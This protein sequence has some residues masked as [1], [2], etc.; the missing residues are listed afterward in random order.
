[1]KSQT[2]IGRE[3]DLFANAKNWKEYWSSMISA[4][5][6]GDVLEVG[7]GMGANTSFLKSSCVTSW[8]CLDPDVALTLQMRENF[9]RHPDLRDCRIEV[10]STE[11]IENGERFDAI[12][13][14]DVLEHISDDKGEVQR[15][16]RL[17]RPGGRLI[18]LAPAYQWLYTPFDHAIGHIR[19]YTK[20]SLRLCSTQNCRLME[21]IYLDSA[22]ILASA[23]NRLFLK[24]SMPTAR[25]ILLWDR[26]LVPISRMIDR[27][28]LHALGKSILA[29]WTRS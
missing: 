1:M 24:Q 11:T 28:I 22:G 5:I 23:G 20:S 15:A 7:A 3:L 4:H 18:V 8:T 21:M 25:Q 17:L 16:C 9:Q 29:V 27:L 12:L 26:Y 6:F 14:I 10:G 13:Y 19:R 2:Y